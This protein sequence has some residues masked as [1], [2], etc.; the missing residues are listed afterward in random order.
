MPGPGDEIRLIRVGT[1]GLPGSGIAAS[2]W[3]QAMARIAALESQVPGSLAGL[4]DTQIATLTNGQLLGYDSAS[5]RWKN[6]TVQEAV[7]YVKNN[8][9]SVVGEHI[10]RLNAGTGLQVVLNGSIPTQVDFSVIFGTAA[11]TVA[12]G[13]HAHSAAI[14]QIFTFGA[15]GVLSSGSRTLVSDTVTLPTGIDWNVVGI[16]SVVARNN[17]NSG[18][19]STGLRLGGSGTYPETTMEYGTVGGVPVPQPWT[20]V[21]P[22]AGGGSLAVTA[23]AIFSSGDP[24]DLR[25]GHVVVL[26]FPRR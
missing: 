18:T 21:R 17:V 7:R 1:P 24:V 12:E 9:V 3:N 25:A 10:D 26:A 13:N 20:F 22:V 5:S 11:G 14:M 2:D 23:R 16:M 6:V 4:T 15:T 8:N 19:F